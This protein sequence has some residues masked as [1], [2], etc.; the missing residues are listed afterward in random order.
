MEKKYHSV[1]GTEIHWPLI[2]QFPMCQT[3]NLSQYFDLQKRP[4][5]QIL[6]KFNVIENIAVSLTIGDILLSPNRTLKSQMETYNGPTIEHWNLAFPAI[7][8]FALTVTQT[9]NSEAEK[10]INC[11]NYPNEKFSSFKE[12]DEYFVLNELNTTYDG[13]MPFWA[14]GDLEKV[15]QQR[16]KDMNMFCNTFQLFS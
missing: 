12:C 14:T 3:I 1:L 9:I 13:I 10:A 7:K 4:P 5:K 15:T 16:Y 2:M 8:R 6:F 11:T